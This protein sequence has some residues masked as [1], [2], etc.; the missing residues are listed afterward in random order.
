MGRIAK[1]KRLLIEEANKRLL[2]EDN[3]TLPSANACEIQ[4]F[5][6]KNGFLEKDSYEYCKFH[7]TSAKALGDYIESKLGVDL[8]IENLKDLQDYM[9]LIGFD[10]GTYGF[11]INYGKKSF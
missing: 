2:I 7:D 6:E 11:G 1:I 9:K 3:G 4:K 5:L 10:T 8:G